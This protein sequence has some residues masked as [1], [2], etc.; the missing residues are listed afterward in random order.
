MSV[1]RH[2]DARRSET[3][4]GVM[5]T[6]ASPTQGGTGHAVWRVDVRPGAEG[7]LHYFDCEQV[8]TFLEGGATVELGG[9][10][11]VVTPGDTVI[12]PPDATRRVVADP[13]AGYAAIVAAPAGA[14][15]FLADG[16]DKGVP[17]WIA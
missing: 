10:T 15:A 14:R 6:F 7:P 17:P 9:E 16:T 4:N 1:I 5:T 8:W 13:S 3:P 11:V 2:A 12:M